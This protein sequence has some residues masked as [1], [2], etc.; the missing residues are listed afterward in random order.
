MD[1]TLP[2]NGKLNIQTNWTQSGG[3]AHSKISRETN[4]TYSLSLHSFN[5]FGLNKKTIHTYSYISVTCF[6][7]LN[8]FHHKATLVA[9][10]AYVMLGIVKGL[11]INWRH[12]TNITTINQRI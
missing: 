3:L 11:F 10:G 8:A 6:T 4:Y 12:P 1:I 2:E 7:F 5:K 9:F